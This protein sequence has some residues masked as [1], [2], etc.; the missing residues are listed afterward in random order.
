MTLS[1]DFNCDWNNNAQKSTASH[2]NWKTVL[3]HPA[4]KCLIMLLQCNSTHHTQLNISQHLSLIHIMT[5]NISFNH[6]LS[7]SNK[8]HTKDNKKGSKGKENG[9][10]DFRWAL[11]D[12]LISISAAS[13]HLLHT[14]MDS[15]IHSA[16]STHTYCYWVPAIE[17]AK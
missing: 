16:A 5:Q 15:W 17:L 9:T 3:Q 7:H 12:N 4:A 14:I 13:S 1:T 6:R 2:S 8:R 11:H 10:R